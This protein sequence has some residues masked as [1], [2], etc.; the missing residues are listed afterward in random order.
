MKAVSG[1]AAALKVD[2]V[3]EVSR[4]DKINSMAAGVGVAPAWAR[5]AT[6]ARDVLHWDSEQYVAE[7]MVGDRMA[8]GVVD[9]GSCKTLMCENTAKAL[10]LV[11]ERAKGSEF[12]TCRVP[13]GT[14]AK[15]YVG[16][17]R[18]PVNIKFSD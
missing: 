9:T 10:G 17:I 7:V 13:G 3:P 6:D 5:G 18:G 4:G 12:G 2:T 8:L 11:V 15:G 16:V 14:D 1:L